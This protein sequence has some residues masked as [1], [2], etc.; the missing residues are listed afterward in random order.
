MRRLLNGK[1]LDEIAIERLREFEKQ[2]VRM[3]PNGYLVKYSGGKDSECILDLAERAGVKYEAQHNLTTVDPPELVQHVKTK[4][5]VTIVKPPKNMWQLIASHGIP[6]RR[7]ARYCCEELKEWGGDGRFCVLGVRWD[8]SARRA[9]RQMVESCYRRK[10]RGTMFISP[11]IDWTT[12]DVWDYI[13]ERGLSYCRLYDEGWDRVGCVLCPMVR[14]V[15]RHMARWPRLCSAWERAIKRTFKPDATKRTTFKSAE[16]YWRW[17][18]D[19][20]APGLVSNEDEP[21]CRLFFEEDVEPPTDVV[22]EHLAADVVAMN[23]NREGTQCLCGGLPQVDMQG[24][25]FLCGK[26]RAGKEGGG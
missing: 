26:M 13:H 19:R 14:D 24:R 16:E 18:L 17:W 23:R 11:I 12:H 4:K 20:D 2:A 25:C 7:M 5:N 15:E 1:T 9:K 21:Q 10:S 22:M 8:E 6:P 3:H